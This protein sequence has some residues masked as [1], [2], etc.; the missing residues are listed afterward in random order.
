MR[1][2]ENQVIRKFKNLSM[3]NQLILYSICISLLLAAVAF[4][5]LR[6]NNTVLKNNSQYLTYISNIN[7]LYQLQEE[8][9]TLLYKIENGDELTQQ[10]Q[11]ENNITQANAYLNELENGF[12]TRDTKLRIRTVKYLLKRYE[13][14]L[15]ELVWLKEYEESTVK[16]ATSNQS[17]SY[18]VYL[19]TVDISDRINNYLQDI[20]RYSVDENQDFIQQSIKNSKLL[21]GIILSFIF[22]LFIVS[23]SIYMASAQYFSRMIRHITDITKHLSKGVNEEEMITIEGPKEM[24]ELTIQFNALLHT[25]YTLNNEAKEKA[26]LEHRLMEEE[27]EQLK[28]REKLKEAQ[29]HGLQMQIQP[30]FLFNTLNIISMMALLENANQ[31]YDLLLALSKFLRHYLKKSSHKVFIEDE[32]DMITQYLKILKARMGDLLEYKV[33]SSQSCSKVRLPMFTLQPIVEN[34][35]KHGIEKMIHKGFILVEVTKQKQWA[36][37]R[38]YNNGI[39]MNL[40]ELSAVRNKLIDYPQ[41]WEED[42]KIGIENVS[43]RLHRMYEQDVKITM[44]SRPKR[45]TVITIWIKDLTERVESD[46]SFTYSG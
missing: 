3:H 2:G 37:I 12:T 24:Q 15:D 30:H 4:F 38:V 32:I 8:N 16:D 23:L 46:V 22:L 13:S 1:K 40:D 36:R 17:A 34:A 21:Q 5:I 10:T 14:R 35:F 39:G 43:Y 20:L 11:L 33:V 18:S 7:T 27:L 45:G 6:F 28:V 26:N 25:L 29:L 31:A 9:K 41:A 19:E 44:F 42:T